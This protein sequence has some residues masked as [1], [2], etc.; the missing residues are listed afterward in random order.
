[1]RRYI[2]QN[3]TTNPEESWNSRG[4]FMSNY[5]NAWDCVRDESSVRR[6]SLDLSRR[7]RD[8]KK[9]SI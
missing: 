6:R 1:M 7:T 9:I 5:W 4:K 2:K 3:Q 8:F